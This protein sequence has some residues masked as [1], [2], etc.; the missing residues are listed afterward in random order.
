MKLKCLASIA[1]ILV[2][3]ATIGVNGVFLLPIRQNYKTVLNN[4]DHAA[5]KTHTP[6]LVPQEVA[7]FCINLDKDQA[8]Y[9][10]I[11]L[12]L[13]QLNFSHHRVSAVYGKALSETFMKSFV[14]MKTYKLFFNGALPGP[15]EVGCF[16]SHVKAWKCFL[17]SSAEF[18]LI[19]EDDAK[20]DP[21]ILNQLV[22]KLITCPQSWDICSLFAP[23]NPHKILPILR[24]SEKYQLV[25]SFEETSGALAILLNRKAAQA[26]LSKAYR[27]TLPLDHYIQRT[28]E[29]MPKLQFTVVMPNP[30]VEEGTESSIAQAG[31]RSRPMLYWMQRN[32]QRMWTQI[33]HAKSNLAYYTYNLYLEYITK[34]PHES[35]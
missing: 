29:F 31:R 13:N 21:A 27:Y 17:N 10:A 5:R 35:S 12:L 2:I 18:A 1:S 4:L 25:R 16:L 28:W 30:I 26:L 14:D 3:F 24:I 22:Q 20:F 9:H 19:F 15:G 23:L 34:K 33:C 8:R 7:V 6:S 32:I 11:S